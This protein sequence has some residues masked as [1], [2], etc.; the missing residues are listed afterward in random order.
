MRDADTILGIIR[1]SGQRGLPLEDIYR[2]LYNPT[3]YLM[4]YAR[5]YSNEGAMT[6]G[7]TSETVDAMSLRK[8]ETLIDELRHERFHWTPVRRTYIP[9][10]NGK[11]RPLGIPTWTDKLLQEVLR[12]ILEA[13]YE[14]QFS[15]HSHGFRPDRGCHTALQEMEHTWTGTKWFIEG[16]IKGCFD[17]LD[18]QVLITILRERLHDNRFIRLIQQLLEAGYL[19]EW[20]YHPTLSGS[21]QGGVVSPILSNIYLDRL[22]KY[23]EQALLP[24]FTRGEQRQRNPVYN[25]LRVREQYYRKQGHREKALELRRLRQ[26]LPERDPLDPDYRRLRYVRYADDF[27]LGFAGPQEEAEEIKQRLKTFLQEQLKLELSE[28]KTLITHASTQPAR[29]LGYELL[30]Q[31]RDDKRDRTDRRCING[32]VALRVPAKGVENKCAF[33]M[34]RDKPHHR[35]ELLNDDDFS[36]IAHYQSEYRGFVQY[37]LLAQNVSWLW[38]LHWVMR[39]SLLKT[40]AHKHRSSVSK[41]AQ[42]YRATIE[43]PH[44]PMKCLEKVVLR[45]GKKPLVARF[46]GIP[47]RRQTLVPLTDQLVSLQKRPV[48]NELLKRLLA[49][50]C[51]LCKSTHQVEVHHLRK[52]ADLQRPGRVDRPL[53]VRVMAARRRK[54]L[55][56]CRECHQ[57]IHA[58]RP[59]RKPPGQQ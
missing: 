56:V 9:K 30:V 10:K 50:T 40:L 11:L 4:A 15:P 1:E 55:I 17:R 24:A 41:M 57:A 44:G 37:Y 48:R 2:Q 21:P 3:L 33:Y 38:K 52:L 12:L 46:G 7:I 18:H 53:W 29:F 36:I 23:V 13:Y 27:C 49:D 28:E 45:E 34:R 42:K 32:H 8:I 16:D 35:A 43:T 25:R 26:S 6:V 31:Y 22:D 19:E 14:P 39:A 54:T 58:G 47:L 59:T 20:R 51:E 5:L